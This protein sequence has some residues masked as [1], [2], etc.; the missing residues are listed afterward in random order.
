MKTRFFRGKNILITGGTGSIGSEVLKQLIPFGPKKIRVFSRD[1][2]KQYQLKFKYQ[3]VKDVEIDYVLGDVRDLEAVIDAS[4]NIDI[5]FHVAAY[6]HVPQS[7]ELPEEF[8][9]T[10]IHGA[11]NIKKAARAN[12]IKNVI[13]IS[14]DKAVYPSNVMGLT[15]AI[16][17]KVFSSHSLQKDDYTSKFVNVRFGNVIGTKGSIFPIFYHQISHGVHVPITDERMT[18]FFM[19]KDEAIELIF[20][21]AINA[22]DGDTVI[23][24][25]KS[26]KIMD[27]FNAFLEVLKQRKDYPRYKMGIRVGEKL[28]ESLV[29]QDEFLKV[30]SKSAYYIISPYRESEIEKNVIKY[31]LKKS[32]DIQE[33]QSDYPKNYFSYSAV[34]KLVATYVEDTKKINQII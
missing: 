2:Y 10:N 15:K 24:R 32:T 17:E 12:K 27:L 22:S 13:S 19:T 14:S 30:K 5:L 8:I 4:R 31:S 16:Q 21:S 28:H 7:E 29:T 3:G 23:R 20:W 33:M 18:R 1:E 34:K 9:K 11:L 6:K 25:M 26:I